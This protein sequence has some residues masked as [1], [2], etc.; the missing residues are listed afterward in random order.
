MRT[1]SDENLLAVTDIQSLFRLT[2]QHTALEVEVAVGAV[3]IDS[4]EGSLDAG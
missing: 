2:V 1:L 4:T 3:G